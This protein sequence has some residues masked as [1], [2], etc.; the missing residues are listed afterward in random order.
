VLLQFLP[1]EQ[2]LDIDDCTLPVF[3]GNQYL[4]GLLHAIQGEDAE[5]TRV[6]E[7]F[8]HVFPSL[9]DDVLH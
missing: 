5:Q 4:P 3:L 2:Q 1:E 7:R 8:V 9:H 6:D